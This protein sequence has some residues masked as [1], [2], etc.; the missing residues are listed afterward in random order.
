MRIKKKL[1]YHHGHLRR[2]IMDISINTIEQQ[3]VEGIN[4]RALSVMTGVSPGAPYHHFE[5]RPALVLA[6]AQEGFELLEAAMVKTSQTIK[7][8]PIEKLEA[9]A[10]TYLHFAVSHPGYFKVMFRADAVSNAHEVLTHPTKLMF[11]CLC[12]AIEESQKQGTAPQGETLPL[13][14]LFWSTIHGLATLLTN[15]SLK[16][17][18]IPEDKLTASIIHLMTKIFDTKAKASLAQ[19]NRS[20]KSAES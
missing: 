2:L 3:G 9:L 12:N 7:N 16:K 6:L 4:F 10:N 8:N 13:A 17:F 5:D 11:E 20:K 14:L 15:E 19:K 1:T 18:F